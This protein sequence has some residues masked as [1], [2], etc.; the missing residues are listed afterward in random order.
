MGDSRI[1]EPRE[2]LLRVDVDGRLQR[3]PAID[4][5]I[6]ICRNIVANESREPH[7]AHNARVALRRALEVIDAETTEIATHVRVRAE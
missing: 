6:E 3:S 5:L 4:H 2:P 7:H 1:S